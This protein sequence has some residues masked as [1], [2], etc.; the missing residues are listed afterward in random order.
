MRTEKK[1]KIKFGF[2]KRS[3]PRVDFFFFLDIQFYD[4]MLDMNSLPLIIR[5]LASIGLVASVFIYLL[6]I[7][8]I[9]FII[10]I[11]VTTA[12]L[13]L[14]AILQFK[15]SLFKKNN[16]DYI[17]V[18]F[19]MGLSL[20]SGIFSLDPFRSILGGLVV[21][22]SA[23]LFIA[24][25]GLIYYI[26]SDF[27][28]QDKMFIFGGLSIASTALSLMIIVSVLPFS[29]FIVHDSFMWLVAPMAVAT[30]YAQIHNYF[31]FNKIIN[32]ALLLAQLF[33][34]GLFLLSFNEVLLFVLLSA[35]FAYLSLSLLKGW[36]A[37]AESDRYFYIIILVLYSLLLV[38]M[39]LNNFTGLNLFTGLFD[40]YISPRMSLSRQLFSANLNVFNLL[41]GS[42][43]G[44]FEYIFMSNIDSSF[45]QLQEW[46]MI[47][48]RPTSMIGVLLFEKGLL[49]LL[50]LL[51]LFVYLGLKLKKRLSFRYDGMSIK[52]VYTL[53]ALFV[54]AFFL[55]VNLV[56]WFLLFIL[57]A[58][59][60]ERPVAISESTAR[61]NSVLLAGLGVILLA[62]IGFQFISGL[63][64]RALTENY[65]SAESQEDRLKLADKMMSRVNLIPWHDS[66]HRSTSMV[67]F[68]EFLRRTDL[69][70]DNRIRLLDFALA[71]A[72]RSVELNRN[73]FLN[74]Q[75][76]GDFYSSLIGVVEGAENRALLSYNR[77]QSL[78]PHRADLYQAEA[79]MWI[80]AY[81]YH[82]RIEELA[83]DIDEYLSLSEEAINRALEL[84]S[85]SNEAM[86]ILAEVYM[87][88][89]DYEGALGIL[90]DL[91]RAN[92]RDPMTPYRIGLLHL[93][94]GDFERAV[95]NFKFS[96]DLLPF[97]SNAWWYLS[98][99]YE[100]LSD[101]ENAVEALESILVYNPDNARVLQRIERLN[102]PAAAPA[103]DLFEPLEDEMEWELDLSEVE[104]LELD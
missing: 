1:I 40:L 85:S 25:A 37:F 72:E 94:T 35:I 32:G 15:N 92:P 62:L 104:E 24:L 77:A 57:L 6:D 51:S 76:L 13:I 54:L 81:E 4:R 29:S 33:A 19:L 34:V 98:I 48:R 100:E 46:R 39:L 30:F 82:A 66:L 7:S 103:E 17:I 50:T 12:L 16:L 91:Q 9:F 90:R 18:A 3:A 55:P 73:S 59:L 2:K 53:I 14:D 47:I 8:L 68:N 75:N 96:V 52:S 84:R 23:F 60:H 70:N 10:L 78:A 65:T 22:D 58:F 11:L 64:H 83:G 102:T 67:V 63:Q 45:A 41:M 44:S 56:F 97:Y 27:S 88:R 99:A 69:D 31:S 28:K 80:R 87:M 93:R 21:H 49:F 5:R 101:L 61:F 36:K 42:G 86:S 43:S 79:I 89:S 71:S 74:W 38:I 95:D 26:V 20:L